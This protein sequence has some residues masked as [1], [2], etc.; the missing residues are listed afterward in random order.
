MFAIGRQAKPTATV[1]QLVKAARESAKRIDDILVKDLRL[2]QFD[3]FI[4]ELLTPSVKSRTKNPVASTSKSA[5]C[6]KKGA[7]RVV[8]GKPQKCRK[9]AG[10]LAWVKQA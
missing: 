3:S 6:A 4:Q 7:K 2:I 8:K 5:P 1:D 10:K 9:V